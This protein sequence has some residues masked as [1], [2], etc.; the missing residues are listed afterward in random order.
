MNII[1]FVSAC[2]KAA[3]SRL[4]KCGQHGPARVSSMKTRQSER[5]L[6]VCSCAAGS[7]SDDSSQC[8]KPPS[9]EWEYS[10]RCW[11]ASVQRLSC[12]TGHCTG[13]YLQ[14]LLIVNKLPPACD[15]K[16]RST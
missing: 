15:S 13:S 1:S 12:P 8:Q 10:V 4:H 11:A 7:L 2:H 9:G 6:A 16:G 3:A 14:H 5:C